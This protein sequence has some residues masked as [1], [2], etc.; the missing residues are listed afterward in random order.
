MKRIIVWITVLSMIIAGVFAMNACNRK[1][2]E[3]GVTYEVNTPAR[4]ELSRVIITYGEQPEDYLSRITITKIENGVSS[5]VPVEPS[6]MVTTID[7][8]VVDGSGQILQFTYS[9]QMFSIP[10]V[11]KYKVEFVANGIAYRTYHVH[12]K[13]GL[14]NIKSLLEEEARAA[15]EECKGDLAEAIMKLNQ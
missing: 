10:V 2:D 9:G 6:M 4:D 13:A 3:N 1:T 8:S 7:T 5:T 11:V 12:N 15:L 14:D